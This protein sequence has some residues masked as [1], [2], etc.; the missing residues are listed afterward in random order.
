VGEG[1]KTLTVQGALAA[2]LC[3]DC[4]P[5]EDA[6]SRDLQEVL[7]KVRRSHARIHASS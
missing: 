4:E 7:G 6:L 1:R 5:H 3:K 2:V